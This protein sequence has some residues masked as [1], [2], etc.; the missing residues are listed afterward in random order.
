MVTSGLADPGQDS[1]TVLRSQITVEPA[2]EFY[3]V[4]RERAFDWA[5]MLRRPSTSCMVWRNRILTANLRS[6]SIAGAIKFL[7]RRL[8]QSRPIWFASTI[9]LDTNDLM[10]WLFRLGALLGLMLAILAIAIAV[11]HWQDGSE[12]TQDEFLTW[13]VLSVCLLLMAYASFAVSKY[14]RP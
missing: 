3:L 4:T 1:W 10:I 14:F 6:R 2:H 11:L 13:A 12:R 8:T 9:N 5:G 7:R